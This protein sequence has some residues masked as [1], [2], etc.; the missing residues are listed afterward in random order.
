MKILLTGVTG[1]IG[2]AVMEHFA[3]KANEI[4]CLV[5]RDVEP[6]HDGINYHVLKG[7][8][9]K[10]ILSAVKPDV[11][12][13]IASLFLAAHSF[14]DID[15]LINSNITFPTK[16]LEAMAEAGVTRFINTG[17]SW[18]NYESKAYSPVNLYS[19]TKQA[20][21]DIVKYYVE[22]RG[23][24]CLTLKIFDSYGPGD[25]RGKL[26]ALLDRLAV[27]QEQLD[28]SPGEQEIDLIHISDICEAYAIAL[29]MIAKKD[30]QLYAEYGLYSDKSYSLK[31]LA[32]VYEK[33]N[34]CKLNINWGGR[35]Y[36][37]REVMKPANNL[38]RLPGWEPKVDLA[39][40]LNRAARN[41]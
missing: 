38:I 21:D 12:V 40:G 11:V 29:E 10:E 25:T 19:A 35:E 24:S 33:A 2:N 27:T 14:D 7:D 22:A 1:Y 9:L 34:D 20:F 17:T 3:C 28:M 4:H 6:A 16:L 37:S 31:E 13:H 41:K 26:V 18:Q 5:R 8:N 32:R 23:F 30:G 39:K 36:R 15:N